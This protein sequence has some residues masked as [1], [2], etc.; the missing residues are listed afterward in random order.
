MT[1][2][3]KMNIIT[4]NDAILPSTTVSERIRTCRPA[5]R[6]GGFQG[7]RGSI[8][9]GPGRKEKK[10]KLEPCRKLSYSFR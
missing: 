10:E 5:V 9:G 7:A 2:I 1:V 3:E 8:S 6:F 4:I